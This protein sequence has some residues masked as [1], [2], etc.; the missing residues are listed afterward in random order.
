MRQHFGAIGKDVAA[1]LKL[2][3][4]HGP[5]YMSDDFQDEI[6]F[7]GIDASPSF[8]REPEG[9]GMAERFIRTLEQNLL[10]VQHNLGAVQQRCRAASP[11]KTCRERRVVGAAVA[12]TGAMAARLLARAPPVSLG[13]WLAGVAVVFLGCRW[14]PAPGW[15]VVTATSGMI[16][17]REGWSG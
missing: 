3:H 4:D 2:R 6:A 9:N 10:W 15:A 8:V 14:E 7:L 17:A 13:C 5:N 12:F 16:G 1:G 11:P